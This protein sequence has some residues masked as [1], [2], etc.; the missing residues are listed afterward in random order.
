MTPHELRALLDE[1]LPLSPNPTLFLATWDGQCPRVRPMSLVR[2]GL[3]FHIGTGR[4]DAK[5][6]QIS[7]HPHVEFVVLLPRGNDTG[8]LRVTGTVVEV[9][10]KEMHEAWA[11]GKGYDVTA[12][13]PGGLDNPGIVV[14]RIVPSRVRLNVPGTM[15]EEELPVDWFK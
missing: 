9:K 11:R 14:Y 1:L 15:G 2:D 13:A 5:S 12:Y 8:Y 10:G 7:A 3:R 6:V 4:S